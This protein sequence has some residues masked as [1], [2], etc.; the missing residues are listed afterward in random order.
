MRLIGGCDAT[1]LDQVRPVPE[2]M[3]GTFLHIG[4]SGTGN[5]TRIANNLLCAANQGLVSEMAHL[6]R[7]AGVSLGWNCLS[8][9]PL[10]STAMAWRLHPRDDPT[11][12]RLVSS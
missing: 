2:R 5:T 10:R 11:D 3:T 4:P 7:R 12:Y 9:A 1:A 8:P 6:V